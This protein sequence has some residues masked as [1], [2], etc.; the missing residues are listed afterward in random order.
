MAFFYLSD[1]QNSQNLIIAS[2]WGHST[3]KFQ[4]YKSKFMSAYGVC[5]LFSLREDSLAIAVWLQ[6]VPNHK[7]ICSLQFNPAVQ[8]LGTYPVDIF[9]QVGSSEC[10]K[11]FIAALVVTAKDLMCII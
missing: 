9:A 1:W 4:I 3:V 7:G 11:L 2:R 6:R 8:L 5:K 10:S